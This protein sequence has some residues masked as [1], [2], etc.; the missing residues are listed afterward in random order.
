MTVYEK[1]K[2]VDLT[3][4]CTDRSL[5]PASKRKT[6][7]IAALKA[8]DVTA[9][10]EP[11]EK[12]KK[13]V[14]KKEVAKKKE[15]PT[16]KETP[17]KKAAPTK[18]ETPAK[19]AAPAKKATS[20]KK[21]AAPAKTAVPVKTAAAP[22][23]N[24][25][26]V[27]P[28]PVKGR[29][30]FK[31][32]SAERKP[33]LT[34]QGP[35]LPA[36]APVLTSAAASLHHPEVYHQK[37]SFLLTSDRDVKKGRNVSGRSWKIRPQKRTSTLV[38]KVLSNNLVKGSWEEK[39]AERRKKKEIKAREN[40]IKERSRQTKIDKKERAKEQEIR[41]AENEYKS[42]QVQTMNT[43]TLGAKMTAMSKK[44]LRQV[45]KTRMN[46]KTGVVELVGAFEK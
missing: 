14:T 7:L 13:E 22:V 8:A 46:S 31:P 2:V 37:G 32:K 1:L 6:D 5:A 34:A 19:K 18:K 4:M 30:A 33:G 26:S 15:T 36:P 28:P 11:A 23:K 43:G 20:S 41:R 38:T 17:A 42:M 44:Q 40:E 35:A 27:A 21:V 45:K 3:K 9:V 39:E 29:G 16:K 24:F 10:E 25:F 12:K